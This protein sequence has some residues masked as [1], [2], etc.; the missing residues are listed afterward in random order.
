[1]KQMLAALTATNL[2]TE[3]ILNKMSADSAIRK[4]ELDELKKGYAAEAAERQKAADIRKLEADEQAKRYAAEAIERKKEL[5]ELEKRYAAEAAAR[6]VLAEKSTA[7]LKASMKQAQKE[8]GGIGHRLGSFAEAMV[9]PACE[10]LFSE[11][12]IPVHRVLQNCKSRREGRHMELDLMAVN[13][14]RLVV[15]EVKFTMAVSDVRDFI[16][17]LP[18]VKHSFPEYHDKIILGAVAGMSMEQDAKNVAIKNGLF[19]IVP[20]DDTVVLENAP[21]FQPKVW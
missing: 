8:L 16:K 2:A 5:E 17:K 1:M 13:D 21:N 14:D 3:Q 12:G 10:M 20:A 6:A 18:Q 4:K 7:E 11:R 15:I 9:A 19:V